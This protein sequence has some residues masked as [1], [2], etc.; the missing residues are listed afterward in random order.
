MGPIV[1]LL[2]FGLSLECSFTLARSQVIPIGAVN[3]TS[4]SG[5]VFLT[6]FHVFNHGPRK[7][8]V[9]FHL[10]NNAGTDITGEIY[11][12]P[13][14]SREIESNQS[15]VIDVPRGPDE[16]G[17]VRD[18]WILLTHSDE[19]VIE[20]TYDVRVLTWPTPDRNSLSGVPPESKMGFQAETPR[21]EWRT[22][23]LIASAG[24]SLGKVA[25]DTAFAV[26]NPSP[27]KT[28]TVTITWANHSHPPP[29]NGSASLQIPPRGRVVSLMTVMFPEAIPDPISTPDRDAWGWL[30]FSADIGI[31]VAPVEVYLPNGEFANGGL[32]GAVAKT[33]AYK[34]AQAFPFPPWDVGPLEG[35]TIDVLRAICEANAPM[36]C[37]FE[38]LPSEDCFDTDGKG[39][40]IV[41]PALASGQV[42]GC[43]SWFRT[44][45]REQLGAEFGHGYSRGSTPQL[46]ASDD[47]VAF[48]DL[49]AE[50]SLDA[51]EVAFFAGFFNDA[52]CLGTRYTD[53]Q[54]VL[55]SS[56]PVGREAM[57]GAL[58]EGEIDLAFWDSLSTV[59]DGTHLV[60]VPIE[61]CGPDKLGLAVYP[62]S[63]RRK[64]QSDG[65]RRDYNCGL[66]LIRANG[67]LEDICN[68]SPHPGDDPACLLEGPPPT[69]QCISD[70]PPL[71]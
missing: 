62:P 52:A 35:V 60:G 34:I 55:F 40:L 22:S 51:A 42:D 50:G 63:K 70:N 14:P 41:G 69:L 58:L 43:V 48:D 20:A 2:L 10:F 57:V 47:N 71:P 21:L 23:F 59:P 11:D 49:G 39:N 67:V 3:T 46:I 5:R 1:A 19:A 4:S 64:H 54:A 17:S 16:P 44:P 8:T 26:V 37:R 13:D 61:T 15:W 66:A 25:R 6:S 32:V 28:A 9:Q 33:R 7:T 68:N 12:S 45:A 53:F 29:T 30:Q 56:D 24:P 38:V 18:S 36:K 65:L 27:D 31:V